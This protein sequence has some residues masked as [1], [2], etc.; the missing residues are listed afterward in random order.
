MRNITSLSVTNAL[1]ASQEKMSAA[2]CSLLA[3][4]VSYDV[5]VK[6][7]RETARAAFKDAGY[8]EIGK[9]CIP[10]LSPESALRKANTQKKPPKGLAVKE[11][12]NPHNASVSFGIF[13]SPTAVDGEA[14]DLTVGARVRVNG[15]T[16]TVEVV[17]PEGEE[18]A[19]GP[20]LRFG[21]D[22]ARRANGLIKFCETSDITSALLAVL[23][24]MHALKLSKHGRGHIVLAARLSTWGA[25][26]DRLSVHQVSTNMLSIWDLPDHILS[27]RE[28]GRD[29]F[30]EQIRD[31]RQRCADA[32]G[33]E[34]K[35]TRS[36]ALQKSIDACAT[37]INEAHLYAAILGDLV[38]GVEA[39]VSK[40][41]KV[42]DNLAS[43]GSPTFSA[44]LVMAPTSIDRPTEP[45]VSVETDENG[46]KV[47]TIPSAEA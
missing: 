23:E 42:F 35:G 20:A 5:P 44:D 32:C 17:P 33:P 25:L 24:K 27:A 4:F 34:R 22:L 13:Y 28:S 11:F 12:P 47:V 3:A 37:L 46:D 45:E 18:K 26:M 1:A 38:A 21:Q 7:P 41:K 29:S 2:G 8:F 10:L 15:D 40:V 14:G 30:I 36:D 31:L 43:G 6:V 16:N 39:D 9:A 19:H